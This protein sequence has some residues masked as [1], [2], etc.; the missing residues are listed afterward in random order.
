MVAGNR[1]AK[2]KLHHN[3]GDAIGKDSNGEKI[4]E[5]TDQENPSLELSEIMDNSVHHASFQYKDEKDLD[6]PATS[7]SSIL[8]A[9]EDICQ[10]K[11]AIVDGKD[12]EMIWN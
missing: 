4:Y 8:E 1:Q 5:I 2:A 6:S 9:D 10:G 12:G 11:P 3:N 7:F